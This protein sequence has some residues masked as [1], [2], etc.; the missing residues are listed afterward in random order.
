MNNDVTITPSATQ[1]AS[2]SPALCSGGDAEVTVTIS[3][4]GIPL[5]ARGV[6][7]EVVSGRLHASSIAAAGIAPE[8]LG[9]T[10]TS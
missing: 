7:F 8:P 10:S 3:Q 1:S 4:G 2:C 9:D 5:A 6:R